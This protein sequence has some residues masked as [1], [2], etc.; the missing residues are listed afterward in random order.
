MKARFFFVFSSCKNR[1][2]IFDNDYDR[3]V[4][5]DMLFILVTKQI[6]KNLQI[7]ALLGLTHSSVSRRVAIMRNRMSECKRR[8]SRLTL[9]N[10]RSRL[11]TIFWRMLDCQSYYS[12][13]WGKNAQD[14]PNKRIMSQCYFWAAFWCRTNDYSGGLDYPLVLPSHWVKKLSDPRTIVLL[15]SKTN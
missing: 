2:D 3:Y 4:L 10:H 5:S 14:R 8:K 12:L 1:Q 11:D 13:E 6:N 15:Q 7:L 9:L